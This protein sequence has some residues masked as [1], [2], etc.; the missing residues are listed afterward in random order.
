MEHGCLYYYCGTEDTA[1]VWTGYFRVSLQVVV[2]YIDGDGEVSCVE[3][4]RSVPALRSKLPPFS[5]HRV[6]VAQRKQDAL[7]L[8][9]PGTH[10][11]SVLEENKGPD[12]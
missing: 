12:N 11:Q 4:V 5:H 2:E 3:G 9:L 6:E 8:I 7:K 10:L 1:C